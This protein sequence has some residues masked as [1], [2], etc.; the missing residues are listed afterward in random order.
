MTSAQV[1]YLKN[2]TGYI[3][4]PNYP[5]NYPPNMNCVWKITVSHDK[6]VRFSF[7][8]MDIEY[9]S[10]CYRDYVELRD[11]YFSSS[12]YLGSYCGYSTPRSAVYSTDRYMYV[13]FYSSYRTHDKGFKAYFEEADK[14][15]KN[16]VCFH[17]KVN[18]EHQLC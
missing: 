5:N 14:E 17:S 16:S 4:S 9:T 1:F 8:S 13:K 10:G 2:T 12:K 6:R 7:K 11:G 18:G 3:T 15:G